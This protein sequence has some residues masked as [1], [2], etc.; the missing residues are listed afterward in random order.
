MPTTTPITTIAGSD[1]V[2][3]SRLTLNANFAAIK[4]TLDEVTALL[5]PSSTTLSGITS[6]QIDNASASLS[7]TILSVSKAAVILGNVTIGTIGASTSFNINGNGGVSISQGSLNVALGNITLSNPASLLLAAGNVSLGGEVRVPGVASAFLNTIGLTST[8]TTSVAV[9][10]LKY[11]VISNGST[12]SASIA[13]LTASLQSGSAGQQVEIY[14]VAGPSGP[15]NIDASSFYGLTGSIVLT[16]T[17]D[18]LKC[19]YEGSSWYLW[20]FT[21]GGSNSVSITR[22]F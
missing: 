7:S 8:T 16:A 19:I 18:K 5:D 13:G 6:V 12:S 17:G 3:L 14:H 1:N 10:G 2:G 11:A 21:M 22:L 4:A 20:D 9:T 15:V